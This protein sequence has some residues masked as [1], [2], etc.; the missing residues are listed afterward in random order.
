M[1]LNALW[2]CYQLRDCMS[3]IRKLHHEALS[4]KDRRAF[5]IAGSRPANIVET[6][7]CRS[8]RPI[9]LCHADSRVTPAKTKPCSN[10]TRPLRDSSLYSASAGTLM[11]IPERANNLNQR[12]G[13]KSPFCFAARRT[14][15]HGSHNAN[16]RPSTCA[17]IWSTNVLWRGAFSAAS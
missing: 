1:K 13:S 3:N 9:D 7:F 11:S 8:C 12:R 14:M 17:S 2:A 5:W 16:T 6:D 10:V 4:P 15:P